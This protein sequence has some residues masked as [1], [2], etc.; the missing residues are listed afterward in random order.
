[1]RINKTADSNTQRLDTVLP[2]TTCVL[3]CRIIAYRNVLVLMEH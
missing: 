2:L 1:M 3:L